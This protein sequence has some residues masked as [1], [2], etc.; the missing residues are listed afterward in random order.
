MFPRPEFQNKSFIIEQKLCKQGIISPPQVHQRDN[1][2]KNH[3]QGQHGPWLR[4]GPAAKLKKKNIN[5]DKFQGKYNLSMGRQAI[6]LAF[7]HL[8]RMLWK[9]SSECS[10]NST[11]K[12]SL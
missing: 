6:Y 2:G 11:C 1:L 10:F 9:V 12:T 4:V 5:P 3:H 7:M 8:F